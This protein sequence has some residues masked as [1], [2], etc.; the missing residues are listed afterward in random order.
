[1]LTE[2]AT[3]TALVLAAAEPA[4]DGSGCAVVN[5][6]GQCLVAAVDPGRPGGPRG[7]APKPS[8]NRTKPRPP[9]QAA[10]AAATNPSPAP[11]RT[12]DAATPPR[13]EQEALPGAGQPNVPPR[14]APAGPTPA[15]LIG[16]LTQSTVERLRLFPP[17]L[18][19]SAGEKGLVGV[20]VW[21]WLDDALT[22]PMSTTA[23][24]GTAQV[25]A[26]AR[27]TS[28]VWSM[29][30]SRAVVRCTGPGTPWNGQDGGSPDCGYVYAQTV[31]ARANPRQ[32]GVD[33]HGDLHLDGD[34]HR[35][36]AG[37]PVEAIQTVSVPTTTTLAVGEVQVLVGRGDS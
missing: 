22:A 28:V 21:L 5:S 19:T 27:L 30:S 3:A 34:V 9:T 8:S 11:V 32:R 37:A 2:L 6:I 1:M 13:Y 16:R 31:P 15:Q 10:S 36:S 29:G 26:T 7:P 14:R 23:T 18:H 17:A 35:E 20:P 25:T 4:K 24:A 12:P 33:D